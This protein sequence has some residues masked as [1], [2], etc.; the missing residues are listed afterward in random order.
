MEYLK[1]PYLSR[2]RRIFGGLG[3]V[4]VGMSAT[5]GTAQAIAETWGTKAAMFTA[6]LHAPERMPGLQHILDGQHAQIWVNLATAALSLGVGCAMAH[7][8]EQL[9]SG[10]IYAGENADSCNVIVV[11]FQ[12][13]AA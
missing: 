11:D 6:E 4:T 1:L 5:M 10:E 8:V 12:E 2:G 7:D 9:W 13:K 3:F